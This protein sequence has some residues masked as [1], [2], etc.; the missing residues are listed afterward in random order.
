MVTTSTTSIGTL[1]GL[2]VVVIKAT[3]LVL[4]MFFTLVF[5]G[6]S[7]DLCSTLEQIIHWYSTNIITGIISYDLVCAIGSLNLIIV[8]GTIGISI[9][10]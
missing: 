9:F 4:N 5:L 10:Q 7:L 3:S 1:S 8:V 2:R 6:H